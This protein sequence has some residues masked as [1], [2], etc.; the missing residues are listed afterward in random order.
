[1]RKKRKHFPRKPSGRR[2]D[3]QSDRESARQDKSLERDVLTCVYRSEHGIS[4]A[5]IVAELKLEKGAHKELTALLAML[6]EQKILNH[7]SKDRFS[8]GK[9]NNLAT[10][11]LE[12][13]PRGFGFVTG[14]SI[15]AG[16]LIYTRDP[17]VEAF[18]LG[19]A[20]HGDT[21]LVRVYKVRQDGR[22]EAEVISVL[23]RG[24]DRLAGFIS[25][26][27]NKVRVTP[28]DPRFPFSVIIDGAVPKDASEGDAVIVRLAEGAED[29]LNFR[30]K[31]IEVL[32]NP[33][34]IDVQMRL[35]IEKFKLPHNFS[36][37]A[38]QEAAQLP[39]EITETKGREDLR[40]ILHVTI[41][42]ETAKDFDDAVAVIKTKKGFRLY[43]SIA[44]VSHFVR[45][46]TP[47]DKDAYERGTSI[48][49]P[50]RVIPMLPE[51]I[52]N[53]LCSLIP[54]QDRLAFTAILDFD[55]QGNT[56][57]KRFVKSI[58]RSHKRF[59]YTTVRQILIDNNQDVRR[60]HKPFLTPLKWAGELAIIL[61][62]LRK[63][64]GAIG[65]TLPEPDI[66]LDDAGRISTIGRAE[67]NF[68]HEIIEQFMLS[69]NEAVAET[70]TEHSVNALYRIHERPDPIKVQEFTGFAKTLGLNL[71][72]HREDP[73]W[74]GQVLDMVKGSPKEY[75]VNNLLLRTM[76]QARYDARNVGH[77][78]LAATDYTHFTSP[79]RR[80]PDLL[81][82]RA[83]YDFISRSKENKKNLSP[84]NLKII[85]PFLSTR[86]RVAVS[87]EREMNDRL[88]VR[89]MQGKIGESF[90]AVISGVNGFAFFVELLELFISGSVA[91]GELHDDYYI[92]DAKHHRLMGER[93]AKMYRIGD[94][95]RVT[96]L[97]VDPRK[98][99]I[100]FTLAKE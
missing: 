58:I 80:Y 53:N 12:Q 19:S 16:G 57:K 29:T 17:V 63:E 24:S 20:R 73:D 28:E 43:V 31:I 38:R 36:E 59:T 15:R 4:Q 56:A 46:G 26:E 23:E 27:Q 69:A 25:F 82:H 11:V 33:D 74:F 66:G 68:A 67:R 99:R 79:I 5:D 34:S 40:E 35:V 72:K 13:T 54:D 85:G 95:V 84:E 50:G 92:Y 47:L 64:R 3:S 93:S 89:Y 76:Q 30:G 60:E 21:V 65:F 9:Q 7:T 2:H 100:N 41:D 22:P 88:K 83:M 71:P 51:K 52:S 70:F 18:R 77:F 90:D 49:F 55:R 1:M 8:L 81:V 10:G 39:E 42:G 32:G 6:V 86:E 91:I 37:Q 78:G 98:N 75:V 48:Y 45:P 87:A 14:L 96:L 61:Q 97:D 44:D 94:L 62:K